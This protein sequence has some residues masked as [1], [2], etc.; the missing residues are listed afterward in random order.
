MDLPFGVIAVYGALAVWSLLLILGVKRRSFGP[1]LGFGIA[2]LLVLNVRYLIDGAPDAIAFFIGIY[3]VLDNLG[4]ADTEGAAALARCPDN[5]CTV[6]GDHYLNHPSWGVAFHDR[7]LNGPELRTNL[8]YGHLIFNSVVFVLMHVQLFRPGTGSNPQWHRA[9][10]RVSFGF[11]TVGTICAI[12]LAA[13]HGSVT[14]YGGTLSMVGFWFMSFCVYGCAV[15]GVAA[16]RKGD[17]DTHRVWMIRFVGSMW[18]SFWLFRVML[19]VLG[20]LLRDWEA[21]ALLICIWFSAPL[22][23]LIAELCRRSLDRRADASAGVMDP[24][25][26]SA[27]S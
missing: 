7:F 13:E 26:A 9:I 18:G 3:D 24:G 2:L 25:R 20:P 4:V 10:G 22:G 15:M 17:A 23:I 11:L 1:F 14:E 12:W 5:A 27:S 19:F 16:I 21:A 8:L 6:W